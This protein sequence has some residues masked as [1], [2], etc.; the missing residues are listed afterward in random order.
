MTPPRNPAG[1]FVPEIEIGLQR[2]AEFTEV[3]AQAP[4]R[5]RQAVD[6]LSNEQLDTL[7]RN[8]TIRQIAHHL[9]DSHLNSYVRFKWTLTEDQPTIKPYNEGLWSKLD[10]ART[11]D[12]AP[13]LLLLEG[14]HGRWVQCIQRL[15]ATQFARSFH[16]PETGKKV[17]LDEALSYYAW[18]SKHHTAQIEWVR[19]QRRWD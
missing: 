6:G 18:H 2:I 19:Q 14:L 9:V 16:H 5:L 13:S 12:L 8:W 1:E 7:Y 10:D 3:L 17:R 4:A 11:G 15:P